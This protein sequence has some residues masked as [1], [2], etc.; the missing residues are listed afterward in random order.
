LFVATDKVV[1]VLKMRIVN[2][3]RKPLKPQP[4]RPVVLRSK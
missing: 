4:Q 2:I 3:K 1:K